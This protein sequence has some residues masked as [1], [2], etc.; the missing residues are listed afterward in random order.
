MYEIHK[1]NPSA[2]DTLVDMSRVPSQLV[3][4]RAAMALNMYIQLFHAPMAFAG[5]V[6][7]GNLSLYGPEHI[8]ARG[9]GIMDAFYA[10]TCNMSTSSCLSG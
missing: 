1:S 3:A 8:P 5:D 10:G 2:N 7:S 4:E 6:P 9:V